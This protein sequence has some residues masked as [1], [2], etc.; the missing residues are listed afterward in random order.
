MNI[1]F[2]NSIGKRK[3]GGGEKWMVKAAKGLAERNHNVFLGCKKNS[4]LMEKASKEGIKTVGVNIH[5]DFSPT[6]TY[7]IKKFLLTNKIDVLICNLNKDVRAAGLAGRLAK[8][9]LI[10][11]RHGIQLC[12]KKL[13]HKI[14]LLNLTDG[15]ITNSQTIKDAYM[16]YGW[17]ND[18]FV[19]VIYNGIKT[20]KN[21]PNYPIEE[22]LPFTKNK[23]I[24]LSAGRL[25]K[26]KGFIYLI[27]TA[28]I[29]KK[30]NNDWIFLIAGKGKL[31]NN[32]LQAIKDDG[33][34]NYVRLIGFYDDFFPIL[35]ISDIFILPSL[36][37]G[38]PNVVMEAMS[39]AKPVIATD[40]NGTRELMIDGE[41]GFIVPLKNSQAFYNK[42]SILLSDKELCRRMGK[43]GK[44]R[45]ETKFTYKKMIDNLESFLSEKLQ[46]KAK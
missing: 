46:K 41:T 9:P 6:N 8:T 21:I 27:K 7:K 14:T 31:K 19:K 10:F 39:V 32:L 23:K 34:E 12:G 40:V 24:I 29:A 2:S 36:F 22:E 45:V 28:K 43:A 37:E 1:L 16:K 35:K 38:M 26:Q 5:S 20:N 15:I 18:D 13:K 44:K 25:S 3:W 11:A 42:L 30:H 33:L 4:I 17:F